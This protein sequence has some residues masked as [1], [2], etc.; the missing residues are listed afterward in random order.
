MSRI[1]DLELIAFV[2]G[3]LDSAERARIEAA[4]AKDPTLA[5]RMEAHRRLATQA[6]EAFSDVLRRP[7]PEA[8]VAQIAAHGGTQRRMAGPAVVR[9]AALAATLLVGVFA[10]RLMA[11]QPIVAGRDAPASLAKALDR[12]LAAE[13]GAVRIG[14]SFRAA[15]G[16]CRTFVSQP[17]AVSGL[18]CRNAGRWRVHVAEATP[19]AATYRTAAADSPAVLAA[20]DQLI[21]GQ[22]LDAD[23]EAAARRRGWR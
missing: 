19:P 12:S 21:V 10:G 20:V 4:L 17:A 1:E 13:P 22:P 2:D 8:M 23:G 11:P 18:A 7:P 6:G 5:A 16:Y 14:L 3:E 15:E 9:W